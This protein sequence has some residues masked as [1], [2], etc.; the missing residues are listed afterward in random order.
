MYVNQILEKF[1]FTLH[2]VSFL[3]GLLLVSTVF[4]VPLGFVN[5]GFFSLEWFIS[6]DAITGDTYPVGCAFDESIV[7]HKVYKILNTILKLFFKF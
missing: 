1:F 4:P 5:I 2:L 3:N 7:H 6:I